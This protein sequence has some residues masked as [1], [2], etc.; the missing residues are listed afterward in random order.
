MFWSR[1]HLRMDGPCPAHGHVRRKLSVGEKWSTIPS[2][3]PRVVV[4]AGAE[5]TRPCD[6]EQLQGQARFQFSWRARIKSERV[7]QGF[8]SGTGAS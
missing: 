3:E 1:R 5:K 8:A 4:V 2:L 6:S 7:G